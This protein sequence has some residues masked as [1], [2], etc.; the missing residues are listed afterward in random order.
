MKHPTMSRS[1]LRTMSLFLALVLICLQE[2]LSITTTPANTFLRDY[3]KKKDLIKLNP[4][5]HRYYR[6]S[7]RF[8]RTT[9]QKQLAVWDAYYSGGGG[10]DWDVYGQILKNDGSKDGQHF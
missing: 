8:I 5:G 2:T 6:T 10:Q 1:C 4:S 7:P 3:L 9:D